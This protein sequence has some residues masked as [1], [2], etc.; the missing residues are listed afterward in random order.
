MVRFPET[1]F[2]SVGELV[3][4][5]SVKSGLVPAS[6]QT[7]PL[8]EDLK[9]Y[10][11]ERARPGKQPLHFVK[12]V[13]LDLEKRF[14]KFIQSDIHS[15]ATFAYMCKAM[16]WYSGLIATSDV[17]LL[18]REQV[19]E[20]LWQSAFPASSA[21]LLSAFSQIYP[22]IDPRELLS[23][24][25]PLAYYLKSI[26]K[27]GSADF[28]AI[29]AYRAE[30]HAIDEENARDTVDTWFKG[31]V[32]SLDTLIEVME[33]LNLRGDTGKM[34]WLF[35]ARLLS[36]TALVKRWQI[37]NRIT[38][39]HKLPSP[40]EQFRELKISK[41]HEVGMALNIGMDRPWFQ[42]RQA[43]YKP[44]IAR[45]GQQLENMIARMA[46]TWEPI[47]EMTQH[48]IDWF[49]GRYLALQGR[50]EEAY[51]LYVDG[52][53]KGVRR[54]KDVHTDLLDELLALAG[55][56]GKS[57]AVKRYHELLLLS[58]VTGWDG[59]QETLEA[60]FERK[61]PASLAY[62]TN[63]YLASASQDTDAQTAPKF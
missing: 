31:T 52:Y 40:Y 8:Y 4:E 43:L 24:K 11:D 38:N 51:P 39:G 55:K 6:K 60:H 1:P 27:R 57:K 63:G 33:A 21:G 62:P 46:K 36:K 18:N 10:K 9:A 16:E 48:E 20:I 50:L 42:I 34:V 17:T 37:L 35:T 30:K 29:A 56:L 41:G 7:N 19:V 44:E 54:N 2:P 45:D 14:A 61:F 12:T 32:P 53:N 3:F 26:C 49:N 15:V 59:K 22:E 23:S 25:E 47:G 5:L 28:K 58:G 13:L